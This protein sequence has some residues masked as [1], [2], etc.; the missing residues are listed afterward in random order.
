MAIKVY[1]AAVHRGAL[2]LAEARA[3][4]STEHDQVLDRLLSLRLLTLNWA[5][6]A[7]IP[8]DP[9]VAEALSSVPLEREIRRRQQ[10][11]SELQTQLRSLMPLYREHRRRSHGSP[12]LTCLDDPVE[13]RNELALLMRECSTE[14]VSMQPGGGRD[15]QTLRG[16]TEESLEMLSRGIRLRG[17]YQHTARS[18][19]ATRSYVHQ[20]TEKGAEIRT[21]VETFERMMIFDRETAVVAKR[22][23]ADEVPGAAFITDPVMV[24]FLYRIFE[25]LWQSARPFEASMVETQT[26][27]EELRRRIL[28]LMADGLKDEAIA[29][30]MGMSTRTCR[31][32]IKE[33]TDELGATSR[34][35]AGYLVAQ[36]GLNGGPVP[37]SET[38]DI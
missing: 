10:E 25:N 11:L 3:L 1:T 17:I 2:P 35:Q 27:T 5:G 9:E 19:L 7:L 18:S 23:V 6:D 4:A 16:V 33:I 8:T 15:P 38:G 28:Q 37:A 29:K 30:R 20:V 21:T 14:F 36:Q 22:R 13:V 12:P 24:D 34:F 32:Y 26:T 31:R